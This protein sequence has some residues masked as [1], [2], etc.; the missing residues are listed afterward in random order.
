MIID[1]YLQLFIH[2]PNYY[3]L[4]VFSLSLIVGSFLNVVIYRLPKI[5]ER[6]EWNSCQQ[7]LQHRS[8][9]DLQ[10]QSEYPSK[11]PYNL[12]TP[13]SQCTH[14]QHS[15]SPLENIPIISWLILKGRCAKCGHSI[16]LR[17]PLVEI[18]TALLSLCVAVVGGVNWITL[19]FILL[20]W[21]L[22]ALAL[23][24]YDTLLLPDEITLPLIW[25]GLL[26]STLNI[27]INPSAAI[28]G[29]SFGYL[30]LWSINWLY[31]LLR[32]QQGIGYGDFKLMAAFGAWLGWQ[33]VLMI[34]FLSSFFG[35]MIGIMMLYW[36]KKSKDTRIPFGPYIAIAGWVT[37]LWGEEIINIYRNYFF[38][39]ALL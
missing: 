6:Q 25:L 34:I 22:I 10:P 4:A 37:I 24:D 28:I 35:A 39:R 19:C 7:L 20:T 5:L 12:I 15:L 21:A 2:Y 36:Q 27:G 1:T 18:S 32:S 17:Y 13:R 31:S 38:Y 9:T 23:I 33:K 26:I 16:S 29:A 11:S 8:P 3:Y 30:S 14:C